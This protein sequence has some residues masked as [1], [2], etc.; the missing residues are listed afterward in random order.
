MERR[1]NEIDWHDKDRVV[2]EG[3]EREN[4]YHHQAHEY[5]QSREEY[6]KDP[7]QHASSSY[8]R[9]GSMRSSERY[10]HYNQQKHY[11]EPYQDHQRGYYRDRDQD[12]E[13]RQQHHHHQEHYKKEDQDYYSEKDQE[14]KYQENHWGKLRDDHQEKYESS[15]DPYYHKNHYDN[16]YRDHQWGFHHDPQEY[17]QHED[18]QEND[19]YQERNCYESQNQKSLPPEPQEYRAPPCQLRLVKLTSDVMPEEQKVAIIDGRDGGVSIGRDRS[20]T[21]RIRCPSM[22]VSKHH[23][24]IFQMGKEGG[25]NSSRDVFFAVADTGSTHGTFL[26]LDSPP[27]LTVDALPP[28]TA[29]QRLSPP[30]QASIPK[31]LRHLSLLRVGQTVFQAHL[32]SGWTSCKDCALSEDSSNEIPLLIKEK[33]DTVTSKGDDEAMQTSKAAQNGPIRKVVPIKQAI[34]NLKTRHLGEATAIP[35][36]T[37]SSSEAK[38]QY[39]DR[40][41]ARRARGGVVQVAAPTSSSLP[42][43][44]A[45]MIASPAVPSTSIISEPAAK[46]DASNRGFQMFSSMSSKSEAKLAATSHEPIFA[47]G[48]E[49]RAGLGSKRLLDVQEMASRPSGYS[50]ESVRERQRRRFEESR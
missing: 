29:Y 12:Y 44:P 30:K 14:E 22:E 13:T 17:H 7:S 32:H 34:R 39:V 48:V 5:P 26:L 19:L 49:G 38:K 2:I 40:A 6:Y 35:S 33:K 20:F 9:H 45:A 36:E 8:S 11:Q 42:S 4:F 1:H 15:Y 41:A 18:Q 25:R 50:P 43:V 31:T 47:R 37:S 10:Y 28:I 24:N 16:D 21:A 3:K 23:A 27:G 46:L